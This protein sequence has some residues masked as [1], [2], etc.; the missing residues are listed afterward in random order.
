MGQKVHPLGFRLGITKDWLAKWQDEKNY[1][2]LLHEDL[3]IRRLIES[4]Y[5]GAGISKIEIERGVGEITVTVHTSR[6]GVVIGRGGGRIDETR[7]KLERLTGKRVRLNIQ[8]IRE[9]E[10]DA[11]LV[12]RNIA[13]QLERRVSYRRAMKQA[14]SR[15][16]A[17]GAKG[18]KVSVAGRLV[19]QEIAR[20]V[21]LHEGS[22]PLQTL[23]ADID[24]G[25]TEAHTTTGKIGV[26]V[27]IYKG[28]ILPEAA[29]TGLE[30]APVKESTE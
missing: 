15:A 19:G 27:W 28:N 16:M 5:E 23:I 4:D 26:K 6:P 3:A 12:A 18:I 17:A 14:I 1:A 30:S 10:L 24:Y 8:E 11:Y 7:G 29:E 20:R 21:T 25:F 22:I 13:D 2:K 9:P